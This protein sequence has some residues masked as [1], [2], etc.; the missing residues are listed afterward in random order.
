MDNIALQ[1]IAV[2]VLLNLE[3][4]QAFQFLFSRPSFAGFLLG[5]PALLAYQGAPAAQAFAMD[6]FTA[7]AALELLILD[8]NPVGGIIIPNGVVGAAVSSLML[9][10]GHSMGMAFF[11]GFPAAFLYSKLDF[12]LRAA[13]N[14]WNPKIEA[15]L[16]EGRANPGKWISF[17]LALEAAVSALFLAAAFYAFGFVLNLAGR[18]D[19]VASSMN[20]AFYGAVFAGLAALFFRLKHQVGKNE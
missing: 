11:A 5:V 4:I 17:S 10:S 7:G 19:Y 8:F 18:S 14:S 15:E 2:A 12:Y 1:M 16:A 20:T 6:S 13:R 3:N 9:A